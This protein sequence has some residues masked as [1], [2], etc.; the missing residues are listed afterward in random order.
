MD[1]IILHF[2][3]RTYGE[4]QVHHVTKGTPGKHEKRVVF[5]RHFVLLVYYPFLIFGAYIC[6]TTVIHWSDVLKYCPQI[7]YP[8]QLYVSSNGSSNNFLVSLH[9]EVE[10]LL[11]ICCDFTFWPMFLIHMCTSLE[12][13][14]CT[15]DSVY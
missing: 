7:Q 4:I 10:T 9:L 14:T 13:I 8:L 6:Y 1:D 2:A 5:V 3:G 12:H 15:L 11:A